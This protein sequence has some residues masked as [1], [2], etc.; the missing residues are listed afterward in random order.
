MTLE[1]LCEQERDR[2]APQNILCEDKSSGSGAGGHEGM[3]LAQR[4][5][6]STGKGEGEERAWHP[7]LL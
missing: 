4:R 3:T 6:P 2:S 5:V 1:R 7:G